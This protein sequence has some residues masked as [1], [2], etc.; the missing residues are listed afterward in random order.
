M[1][2]GTAG[3]VAAPLGGLATGAAGAVLLSAAW[4]ACDVGVNA[5]ANSFALLLYVPVLVLLAAAWWGLAVG[6]AARWSLPAGL[7]AGLLGSAV[8]VWVFVALL[9]EPG[10]YTC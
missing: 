8:M 7:L 4:R 3:C 9:R 6:Y 5:S 2:R 1:T 10:G